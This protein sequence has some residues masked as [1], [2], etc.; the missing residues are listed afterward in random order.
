MPGGLLFF[1]QDSAASEDLDQITQPPLNDNHSVNS[2]GSVLSSELQTEVA[3]SCDSLGSS[4]CSSLGPD[5]DNLLRADFPLLID[6]KLKSGTPYLFL[7]RV[8]SFAMH[9]LGDGRGIVVE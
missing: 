1:I 4:E 3:E 6:G 9:Y 5:L 2:V 7:T 8:W